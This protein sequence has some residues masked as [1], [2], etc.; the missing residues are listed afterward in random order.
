M[1][2][3]YRCAATQSRYKRER[4]KRAAFVNAEP[5]EEYVREQLRSLLAGLDVEI[6]EETSGDLQAREQA[7]LEAESELD[8]FAADLT[9]RR[10]LGDRYH[11]H[12]DA[13]V[14]ALE[15]AKRD[16][17]EFARKV[18]VRE[19]IS[20]ADLLNVEDPLI[21]PGLLGG[22]LAAIDVQPGRGNLAGRVTLVPVDNDATAGV[23]GDA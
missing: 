21:L 11:A 2:R 14:Q 13:R 8:A 7:V 20:A 16:Y 4:C 12:L 9:L 1:I 15:Q 19:R 3:T 17:Q 10:A 23:A 5:L 6:G 22:I 18:Q